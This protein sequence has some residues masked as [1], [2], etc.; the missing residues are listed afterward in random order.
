MRL[1]ANGRNRAMKAGWLGKMAQKQKTASAW[2]GLPCSFSILKMSYLSA[3]PREEGGGGIQDWRSLLLGFQGAPRLSR[4]ANLPQ[5]L[6]LLAPRMRTA[7]GDHFSS[8]K[9]CNSKS[10]PSSSR[11][12]AEG[13]PNFPSTEQMRKLRH[14]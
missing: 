10:D 3:W 6:S 5:E 1:S 11:M 4:C 8:R 7:R 2:A 13:K 9:R 12:L 14:K